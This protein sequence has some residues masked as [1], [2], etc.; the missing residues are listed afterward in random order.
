MP[1][2]CRGCSVRN[3]HQ[4]KGRV[5]ACEVGRRS[6]CCY[7]RPKRTGKGNPG[8]RQWNVVHI[9]SSHTSGPESHSA[10]VIMPLVRAALLL[11]LLAFASAAQTFELQDGTFRV[12]GWKPD[13]PIRSED[14]STIFSVHTGPADTP[15]I[16]GG[17]SLEGD[18]LVFRPRFFL[19]TGVSYRAV[20]H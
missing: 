6:R 9:G 11:L 5:A 3:R 2:R 18:D 13:R 20:F 1:G 4:P 14:F 10:A 7:R 16:L 19:A 12:S 8:G 17:Y 15:A